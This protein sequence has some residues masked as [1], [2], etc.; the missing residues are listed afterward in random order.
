M[1]APSAVFVPRAGLCTS[2]GGLHSVC[3]LW[4]CFGRSDVHQSCF[5]AG[6]SAGGCGS[7]L[8]VS[9]RCEA[10]HVDGFACVI[11]GGCGYTVARCLT[12]SGLRILVI[13]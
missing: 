12:S 4:V 2:V 10:L 7:W 11:L 9:G 13:S 8:V 5:L 1:V 3:D 6:L